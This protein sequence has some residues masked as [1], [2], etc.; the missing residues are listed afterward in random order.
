MLG[1]WA[2]VAAYRDGQP[3]LDEVMGVLA[4]HRE[5][6][7]EQIATL[8]PRAVYHLPES[9]YLAWIDLRGYCIAE[10]AKAL[11]DKGRI[12][13]NEGRD[14]GPDGDGFVRLNFATSREI[15]DEALQR[16]AAVLE[17]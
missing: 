2:S 1:A 12:A 17:P 10:P 9:T 15:L 6:L 14:F 7:A 5:Y 11:L 4:G 16:M 13:V 8:L 3:W